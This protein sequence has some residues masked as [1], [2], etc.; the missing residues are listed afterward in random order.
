MLVGYDNKGEQFNFYLSV[1]HLSF[2]CFFCMKDFINKVIQGDCLEVMKDIPD[3]SIDMILTDPPYRVISGGSKEFGGFRASC[4][5]TENKGKIFKHNDILISE[6]LPE[7]KRVMKDNSQGYIFI[8]QLNLRDYLNELEKNDLYVH[9]VLVWDKM[10]STW[11]RFYMKQY[12][13]VI[14]FKKGNAKSINKQG[15]PDIL[16]VKNP[17]NKLHPTEKPI[18]LLQVFVENSSNEN[19]TILDPFA[20]SGTTGVACKNTN[21]NYILIEKEPEYIDIINKRLAQQTLC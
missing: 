3:K 10:I 11:T 5:D 2:G 4:L 7:V 19:D 18:E 13:F 16:R 20:G 14:F 21:R 8:N 17:R 1:T 15:T 6:W 9:R 12:E